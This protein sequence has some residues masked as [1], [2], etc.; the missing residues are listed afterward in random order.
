MTKIIIF[1]ILIL[2]WVVVPING[3]TDQT[4][5]PKAVFFD[6]I[7]MAIIYQ[8]FRR[9]LKFNYFN[10][11]LSWLIGYIFLTII[12]TWY[13]PLV[14]SQNM[15]FKL[16]AISPIL[17]FILAI[18]ASY[19]ALSTLE[20]EDFIKIGKAVC[21]SSVLV[22]LFGIM[23]ILNLNP[24]GRSLFYKPDTVNIFSALLDNSNLVGNYLALSLPI[25]FFYNS[26]IYL[27]G[28]IIILIGIFL[29][30]SSLSLLATFIGLLVFTFINYRKNKKLLIVFGIIL[31]IISCIFVFNPVFNKLKD[32]LSFRVSTWKLV[33]ER[34]KDNPICGQ[35]LGIF[36]TWNIHPHGAWISR[37]AHNDYLERIAEIGLMGL[38]LGFMVVLNSIRNFN[39]KSDNKI[40]FSY[41]SSFIVFLILMFGSFPI[42]IAPL[43]FLGLIN[44]WAVE[45]L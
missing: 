38:T 40:G 12:I 26:P 21:L 20:K 2:P 42:E 1:A 27:L 6:I 10:K 39:Y 3:L 8:A 17:H 19:I 33:L 44:L 45:R 9:G 16:Y 4:K 28:F 24:L 29:S 36:K 25:F 31:L 7:C 23:Q 18:F 37:V 15:T 11:Y 43:A 41:F 5:F 30:K 13:F 22:T 34:I 14:F 32:G 35:G